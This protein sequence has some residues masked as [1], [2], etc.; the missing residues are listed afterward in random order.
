MDERSLL[1]ACFGIGVALEALLL[2]RSDWQPLKLIGCIG[3][4]MLGALRGKHETVYQPLFHVL[5]VFS[6]FAVIFALLFKEDILPALNERLLLS[7]SMIFWFAF[8]SYFY[9]GA[10]VQNVLLI[11]L[12]I[13]TTFT[14]LVAYRKPILTFTVKLILYTW[15]LT[16]VVCLGLFQFPFYQLKLFFQDQEIPW[17]T[18]FDSISAGMAFLYL[19]ANATYIFY[20]IPIPGRNESWAERMQHWHEF[21]DL[22]TR[23]F[24]DDVNMNRAGLVILGGEFVILAL[25]YFFHW[26]PRDPLINALIVLPGVLLFVR[27]RSY[28]AAQLNWPSRASGELSRR[29]F[30]PR[31][32][33]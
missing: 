32:S 4:S 15:F 28:P 23:R 27:R 3:L 17:V 14:I 20:L 12:L 26:L 29:L 30:K 9:H 7:Y 5:L 31:G 22:M 24:E 21:T 10:F 8:F 2:Q 1:I 19:A 25:D 11:I 13:P 33:D 6:M 16:M 18:P